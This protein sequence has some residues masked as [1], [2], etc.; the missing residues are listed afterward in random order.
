MRLERAPSL[1]PRAWLG[2]LVALS[3][4]A[5]VPQTREVATASAI[6]GTLVMQDI[7]AGGF[8]MGTDPAL[9]F[10]NG[11]PPHDVAIEA[12]RLA[13]TEVTFAQYDAFAGATGRELPPDE[14]WG[15]ES[16]PVVHISWNDAQA[17]VAWLNEGTGRRFRLPTEAEWE[18]AARAGTTSL[19]GWGD[20]VDHARV[21]NSVDEGPDRFAFTAPVGS[22][23]ANDFGLFDMLGNVWELVEDCWYPSYE[24]APADGSA[25]RDG[26]CVSRVARGGSWGSTSR[27]VQIAARGAA[28]DQF[29]SMD[30]GFRL[31]EDVAR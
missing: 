8:V 26:A 27:G 30:L 24:A 19:Y 12:F 2:I 31:A 9:G 1:L 14:G 16:R 18:Y 28:G 20:Q 13:A 10:Q 5:Q 4:C 25:R 6:T 17:F 21:N 15:R 23:P 11:Y 7:P 3:A 29:A 22:F